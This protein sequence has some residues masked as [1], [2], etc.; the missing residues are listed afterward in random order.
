L[1]SFDLTHETYLPMQKD[2]SM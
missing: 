1:I 2:T